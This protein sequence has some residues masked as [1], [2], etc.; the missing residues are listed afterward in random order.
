[1]AGIFIGTRN[2]PVGPQTTAVNLPGVSYFSSIYPFIDIVR[3]SGKSWADG[4]SAYENSDDWLTSMP[5]G[6]SGRM[7]AVVFALSASGGYSY[8]KPG[9]YAVT[10]ASGVTMTIDGSTGI[11]NIV[12]STSR[13]TFTVDTQSSGDYL[14]DIII[15]ITNSTG[16]AKNVTDIKCFHV[17]H[18][19]LLN[20][21]EIFNPDFLDDL[22][23]VAVV[24]AMD[25]NRCNDSTCVSIST[26]V[27]EN[28]RTFEGFGSVLTR[29]PYR[30][31]FPR[32]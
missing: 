24:R 25:W 9:N 16:S 26:L 11:S 1:M 3:G 21:G 5:N 14:A 17:D 32:G 31:Q 20:A 30:I 13:C 4:L 22:Q 10:S 18:E 23:H 7:S 19:S 2:I 29:E 12:S 6:A 28:H 15:R 8:I 27:T